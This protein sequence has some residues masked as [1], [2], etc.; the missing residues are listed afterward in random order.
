MNVLL[1]ILILAIYTIIMIVL[2]GRVPSSLSSSVFTINPNKR[3][4]WTIVLYAV[5]ALC[6]P[7]LLNKVSENTQVLAFFSI[8]GFM[9]VGAAPL[10]KY[11]DDEMRYNVHVYGA[12][13]AAI[14]SQFL[15]LFNK[16]ILLLLWLPY[17]ILFMF[18]FKEWRTKVFWAE[19]VCFISIFMLCLI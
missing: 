10:C 15:V 18:N 7:T 8:A 6:L 13:A 5:G 11:K 2:G 17:I 14:L 16:P 3:W 9:F 12:L 4:I 19:M 1:A